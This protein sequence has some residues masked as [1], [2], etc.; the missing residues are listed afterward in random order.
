[1]LLYI[2]GMAFVK[3]NERQR[4]EFFFNKQNMAEKFTEKNLQN[5]RMGIYRITEWTEFTG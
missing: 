4:Y 5:Y 1:M 3:K 2:I